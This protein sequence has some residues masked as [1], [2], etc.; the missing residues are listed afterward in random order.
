M[1]LRWSEKGQQLLIHITRGETSK[2]QSATAACV[3]K[4]V[5]TLPQLERQVE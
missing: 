2:R 4:M 1:T 3:E 5:P